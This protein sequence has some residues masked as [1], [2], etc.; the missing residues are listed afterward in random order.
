MG[1][2]SGVSTAEH[3]E[4]PPCQ[5]PC[6]VPVCQPAL[7]N[8]QLAQFGNE[9]LEPPPSRLSLPLARPVLQEREQIQMGAWHMGSQPCSPVHHRREDNE[10]SLGAQ[11]SEAPSD[12]L[13][14]SSEY[15]SAAYE[16]V[17]DAAYGLA[18]WQLSRAVPPPP[19]SARLPLLR[20]GSMVC[21]VAMTPTA[22]SSFS[23]ANSANFGVADWQVHAVTPCTSSPATGAA[24]FLGSEE[25]RDW[26]ARRDCRVCD[27]SNLGKLMCPPEDVAI[28]S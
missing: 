13:S 24:P 5:L 16:E 21:T 4:A 9:W 22:M 28:A 27:A 23:R 10:A 12:R 18:A 26:K 15:L 2:S 19:P 1:Q 11:P 3:A 8:Q 20:G 14:K 25:L 6:A 7:G 17:D